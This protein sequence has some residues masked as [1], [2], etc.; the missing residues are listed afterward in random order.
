MQVDQ[1]AI[2]MSQTICTNSGHID[3]LLQSVKRPQNYGSGESTNGEAWLC[4]RSKVD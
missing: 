1:S 3:L 4:R 2:Q